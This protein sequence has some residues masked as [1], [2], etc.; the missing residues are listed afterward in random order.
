MKRAAALACALVAGACGANDA[1]AEPPPRS[2]LPAD[3]GPLDALNRRHARLRRR[4][5]TRA[6]GE[7]VG[8]TRAFVLEDRGVAWPLDLAVDECSTFIALGGGSVRAL[9]LTLYDG[10]G[11]VA[12]TDTVGG[13]GGL[14]HVCPQAASPA[15]YR[16]HY[17]ELRA[18][19]GAGAVM[20]AQ[21][22]SAP[23]AGEG[24]DGLFESVLA[25][26]VPFRDVEEHLARSRTALRARG[27]EPVD[28]PHLEHL[29][30]GGVV[31]RRVRLEAGRCYALTGRSGEGIG[32][33]DLF[34]FDEAGVEV[35][36]DL[37]ADVEPSIEHC[38]ERTGRYV[39][40]LRVFEGAGAAG[41]MVLAGRGR[42]AAPTD[43]DSVDEPL[44]PTAHDPGL[45]LGVLVAPLVARGFSAPVF[46][47]RD[48]AIV[49]GEV[50]THDAVVGP[51]C[52]LLVGTSSS[53]SMDLDLYLAEGDGRE[54]DRDIAVQPTARVRACRDDATVMRV[55]VKGYGRDGAYALAVLRAPEGI[56][57]LGELRLEEL[58]ATYRVRGYEERRRFTDTL[59]PGD[60]LGRTLAIEPGRCVAV[61]AAGGD[62]DS[63][64]DL[65]LRDVSGTLSA[66]DSGPSPYAAV[67]RCA[68]DTREVLTFELVIG[69]GD[70][71]VQILVLE[72][73]RPDAEPEPSVDGETDD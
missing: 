10:D 47:S 43:G 31:R 12:A 59:E 16:S 28:A 61:A 45:A 9:S 64:V 22:R 25:P 40:E 24:F 52:A 7:E 44:E 58:T 26:R 32:D 72:G 2:T 11:Q 41:L 38:P 15:S 29:P 67:S 21:F 30:E 6:Y 71:P 70:G 36:R 23:G 4:M 57:T 35:A 54:V 27:F 34:L 73:P 19:E 49:P 39:V 66:S 42:D 3:P 17:L 37:G 65:L 55:A 18:V 50:R 69:R 68:S 62:R 5:R 1:P 20:I 8:L 46:V 33:I 63:D 13:E 60:R 48:A 53:E 51:G 56:D 14:V